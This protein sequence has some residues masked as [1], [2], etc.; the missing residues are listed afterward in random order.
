MVADSPSVSSDASLLQYVLNILISA[1]FLRT[2]YQLSIF[3]PPGTLKLKN[4]MTYS[5]SSG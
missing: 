4:K 1:G 2:L 5:V 3:Q